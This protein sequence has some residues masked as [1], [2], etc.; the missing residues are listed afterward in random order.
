MGN[1][2]EFVRLMIENEEQGI[3]FPQNP[4]YSN[5]SGMV[6][7]IAAVH[8]KKL[9]LLKG[10]TWALKILSHVTGLVNKAFGNLSYDMS[11]SE[12]KEN[13]RLYSLE[14]SIRLTES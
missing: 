6:K 10:F 8:G 5:T 7:T 12:Y 3:F 14:E 11:L 4:S 9:R 13:Y 1:L 2:A